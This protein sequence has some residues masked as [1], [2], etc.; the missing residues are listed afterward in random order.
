MKT[1][2]LAAPVDPA[3]SA[4]A[5][6]VGDVQA[7]VSR[8]VSKGLRVRTYTTG[9]A[10]ATFGP[11]HD[12]LLIR[13]ELEGGVRVD[14]DARTAWIPA[15][16]LWG[17]VVAAT[18]PH[19]LVAVHGTAATVGVVGYLLRGGVSFYSRRFGLAP[20]TV[21]SIEL[22]TADG[23][24]RT[25]DAEL[26]W[27]LRGG[28]GGFG[29]VTAVE[30]ELFPVASVITGASFWP[31]SEAGRVV[32]L[33]RDWARE[34]PE[35]VSTS[36]RLM[37]MV[38]APGRPESI[39]SGQ[40]VCVDGA[41]ISETPDLADAREVRDGLLGPLGKPV[42]DTWRETGPEAVL[43]THMDP[44]NPVRAFGDHMLLSDV[45]V[46]AFVRLAGAGSPLLSAELRQ[47]GGAVGRPHPEGGA[48]DHVAEPFVYQC[49]G[50]A[51]DPEAA[52]TGKRRA[53]L[54]RSE[55]APWDTG[56]TIPSFVGSFTQPQ[57]HLDA[58]QVVTVDRIRQKVDPDGVFRG[59]IMPNATLTS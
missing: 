57:G 5:H 44:P 49:V 19:G 17:A 16:T 42:H 2:N 11:M 29:V 53:G 59:D 28:G 14:P 12:A 39:T 55:L 32:K 6:T 30:V 36:L 56:R 47:L 54:I 41:I 48:L 50:S 13:T 40:V 37:N 21:R 22:V 33:W 26:L 8:A 10:A 18:S 9:H 1:F 25:A 23:Q 45:D 15:G 3:D 27:A 4:V 24:V 43:A 31:V 58:E 35:S 46:D 34:A 38:A 20:N 51:A 7:A 52:A